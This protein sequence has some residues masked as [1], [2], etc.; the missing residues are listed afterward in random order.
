MESCRF[1][2]KR[3][4]LCLAGLY[5]LLLCVHP[6]KALAFETIAVDMNSPP[7]AFQNN[8]EAQGIYP[9][10]I[11]E[12]F[13]RMN[14]EVVV[15]SMPWKR[16]LMEVRQG[17]A[18]LAGLYKTVERLELFDYTDKLYDE[19][20]LL[21]VRK[22]SDYVYQG[23]DSLRGK[24][25]GVLRGWSYGDDFDEARTGLNVSESQ[26]DAIL[27][28]KL[29]DKRLDVVISIR[30]SAESY[31]DNPALGRKIREAGT[32]ATIATYIAFSK[33][34]NQ[35]ELIA[36]I[37]AAIKAMRRDGTFRAIAVKGAQPQLTAAH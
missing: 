3:L 34:Q 33:A 27:L 21:Y 30:D 16:G 17:R 12:I 15:E 25:V 36:R 9:L 6:A 1:A 7:F 26:T 5:V 29:A 2:R 19:E 35:A 4:L 31:L 10:L 11:K 22:D 32:Y 20:L 37:N 13:R 23:L 24:K 28:S 8:G 18:G 14:T